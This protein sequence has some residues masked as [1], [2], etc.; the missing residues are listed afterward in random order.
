MN[1]LDL[2]KK[3]WNKQKNFPKITEQEIYN[4][5]HRRSS[6]IVKWIFVISVLEILLWA[7]LSFILSDENQKKMIADYHLSSFMNVA[8][9]IHWAILVVFV[10]FFYRNF[11][12]I[13]VISSSKTLMD[14]ILKVRK[15]VQY[16]VWYNIIVGIFCMIVVFVN[17]M[18]YD[19]RI[20]VALD[21]VSNSG[22]EIV[23]WAIVIIIILF[24]LLA[25]FAVMWVFYRII[26]GILLKRLYKNYQE[27]EKMEL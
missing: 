26:Y 10:Y 13:S 6:S 3:D 11:R 17:M 25:M 18:M 16:Y 5:I 4:M 24:V 19:N 7:V 23:F 14:S 9:V 8:T 1:E 20:K 27:L 15:V 12:N 2:L 22:R 21:D